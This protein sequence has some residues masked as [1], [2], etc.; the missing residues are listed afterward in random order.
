MLAALNE[1][2]CIITLA[3]SH[4]EACHCM[5]EGNFHVGLVQL[6]GEDA[7]SL[8]ALEGLVLDSG[9]E[10]VALT[11]ARQASDARVR[12]ALVRL[13]HS[14][15]VGDD[16]PGLVCLLRNVAKLHAVSTRADTQARLHVARKIMVGSTPGMRRVVEQIHALADVD[17]PVFISGESGTGK[18]LAARA[19][20]ELSSR[21]EGPF[22]AVNCGAIPPN[23]I[24]S[25]LFGFEK[26]AFTDAHSRRTG[27]IEAA[28]GGT[29]FLDE[30]SELP[31]DLQ[32][33]LLRFIESRRFFRLGSRKETRADVR[34]LAATNRDVPA[35]VAEGRFRLDL[36]YR[37]NV[38]EI[39]IPPLRERKPDIKPLVELFFEQ[40][41]HYR[42]SGLTGFSPAAMARLQDHD[43]PGNIRELMNTVC[44][45]MLMSNPPRIEAE[46]IPIANP[47]KPLQP[48]T[49]EEIRE[50]A[51]RST[52][53]NALKRNRH[54]VARTSRELGVSRVTLYRLLDKYDI[55]RI[56]DRH[57]SQRF[58]G[59]G[60]P[61]ETTHD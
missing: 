32:A 23:L 42:P 15:H 1:Q 3:A 25:E 28:A 43:W 12:P 45:A 35:L 37:L 38:L 4:Q 13:F 24:Q 6:Q 60:T 11:N 31:Y 2:G 36:F 10:W 57:S 26:G 52:I 21:A 17:A 9:F 59:T 51:E 47:G 5:A 20:H 61:R 48:P 27:K 22:V 58:P 19:I 49:L 46:D 55:Q 29:L 40:F 53:L 54:N 14:V 39:L 30:I 41:K 56:V 7:E 8:S 34:I 50:Q 44:R 16:L 18:E 33:T